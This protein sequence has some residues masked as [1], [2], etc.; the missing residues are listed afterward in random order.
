MPTMRKS[1][2]RL[3]CPY[4]MR[5]D[6][7]I[8]SHKPSLHDK[9]DKYPMAKILITWVMDVQTKSEAI[10]DGRMGKLI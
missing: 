3:V 1:H 5:Y 2:S 4:L 7:D 8:K 6:A 10:N 9:W